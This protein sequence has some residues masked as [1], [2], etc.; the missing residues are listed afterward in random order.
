MMLSMSEVH[1][2]TQNKW[3]A[4]K[5]QGFGGVNFWSSS[6]ITVLLLHRNITCN[7]VLSSVTQEFCAQVP[8]NICVGMR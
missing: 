7:L 2:V 1:A 8:H 4:E 3:R 5:A 6:K